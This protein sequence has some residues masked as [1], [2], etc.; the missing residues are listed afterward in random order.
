NGQAAGL[1]QHHDER[2][3]SL[4]AWIIQAGLPVL[5]CA[6]A[7]AQ[8]GCQLALGQPGPA[9]VA[10]QQ[11]AKGLSRSISRQMGDHGTTSNAAQNADYSRKSRGPRSQARQ[12]QEVS[13]A[14]R[15]R[16]GRF[17]RT[18]EHPGASLS[19]RNACS[20]SMR[21]NQ[22][23]PGSWTGVARPMGNAPAK[24]DACSQSPARTAEHQIG[25]I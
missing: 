23:N 8:A 9:A 10:Q 5:D 17:R 12:S 15:F 7:Y 25:S 1:E 11:T 6:P 13:A 16:V 19:A 2:L 14:L 24:R 3:Q 22:A 21:R 18:L 20:R 4:S